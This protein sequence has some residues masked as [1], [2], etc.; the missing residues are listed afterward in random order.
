MSYLNLI[1]DTVNSLRAKGKTLFAA[2]LDQFLRK[3]A[4]DLGNL[5]DM[6]ETP[7]PEEAPQEEAPQE[8]LLTEP[9]EPVKEEVDVQ[10]KLERTLHYQFGEWHS[11]I[12]RMLP[13]FDYFGDDNIQNLR[14]TFSHVAK[15]FEQA[16]EGQESNFD[17]VYMETFKARMSNVKDQLKE[18]ID[19]KLDE[20]K[21]KLDASLLY[22]ETE[23]L[24]KSFKRI[25]KEDPRFAKVGTEFGNLMRVFALIIQN[26]SE[27]IAKTDLTEVR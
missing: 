24:H 20:T 13:K 14:H 7:A 1:I 23:K 16:M 10:A 15:V 5:V 27:A 25:T 21:A 17:N 3:N 8:E 2:E 6:E 22:G 11:I 4:Q 26:V 12:D 19:A 18:S 9:I